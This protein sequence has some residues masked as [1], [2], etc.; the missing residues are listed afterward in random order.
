MHNR[1]TNK[2]SAM[3][4]AFLMCSTAV[5]RELTGMTADYLR[6]DGITFMEFSEMV[7]AMK[8]PKLTQPKFAE[9]RY[10]PDSDTIF[11]GDKNV[12]K[13]YG[14]FVVENGSLMLRADAAAEGSVQRLAGRGKTISLQAAEKQI[15]CEVYEGSDGS[16]IVT[17]PFQSAQVIVKS[18]KPVDRRNALDVAEGFEDLHV[19]QFASPADA[20][21]AYQ[22]YQA[23]ESIEFAVPN[24]V[25]Q[26]CGT[27]TADDTPLYQQNVNWGVSAI[28]ADEY[29]A[30]MDASGRELPEIVVAVTDT[31]IN[32]EH[33]WFK[34]RIKDG[35]VKLVF[36][37]NEGIPNDRNQH[38]SHCSGII[39]SATTSNVKIL[40]VQVLDEYG[41][42]ESL[43]IYCGVRY[44]VEQNADVISMSLG[45]F[46]GDSLLE[47]AISTAVNKDIP[48]CI[49]AGNDY[50]TDC[51]FCHPASCPNV[52]TVSALDETLEL[53]EYSNIGEMI[54]FAAPGTGIN[55]ADIASPTS[56][57]MLDGTSM[58]TPF[59]AACCADLLTYNPDLTREQI[60]QLLIRNA[61]DLGDE[62]FDRFFGNG[63]VSL[64]D[65][66]LEEKKC[67]EPQFSVADGS[68]ESAVS[69]NIT[70]ETADAEIYYTL[71]GTAPDREHGIR[72]QGEPLEIEKSTIVRA[73]SAKENY[74]SRPVSGYYIIGSKDIDNALVIED[75]VLVKYQGIFQE[76]NLKNNNEIKA[77][78]ENAF[79]GNTRLLSVTLPDS[80]GHV[81]DCAFMG[82]THLE[83]VWSNAATYGKDV[84]RSCR[85]LKDVFLTSAEA[86]GEGMFRFCTSLQTVQGLD[87]LTV[88]PAYSFYLCTKL[89]YFENSFTEIGDYAFS[90]ADLSC[91]VFNHGVIFEDVVKIGRSAFEDAFGL[92]AVDLSNCK[93]LGECAFAGSD[94]EEMT[95]SEDITV[96]PSGFLAN[97]SELFQISAPSVKE[98]GDYGLALGLWA[99]DSDWNDLGHDDW[100]A[101]ASVDHD[102]DFEHMTHL[103]TC[104]MM[105]FQSETPVNFAA[106]D[107]RNLDAFSGIYARQLI[108]PNVENA[109]PF[110]VQFGDYD[111]LTGFVGTAEVTYLENLKTV[112]E[113]A[114][115]KARLTVFGKELEPINAES[116]IG[117]A[118][119]EE[120]GGYTDSAA[121]KLA[122]DLGLQFYPIPSVILEDIPLEYD[123]SMSYPVTIH[124]KRIA[125]DGEGSWNLVAADGSLSVINCE[126]PDV[127]KM[128]MS[129]GG[130]WTFRYVLTTTVDGA[131]QRVEQ[132]VTVHVNGFCDIPSE[133]HDIVF[134]ENTLV[135]FERKPDDSMHQSVSYVFSVD[136]AWDAV[137]Y[138]SCM[139]VSIYDSES[140][141]FIDAF[142]SFGNESYYYTF[143]P[144]IEYELFC[145]YNCSEY[146]A[147]LLTDESADVIS[148]ATNGYYSEPAKQLGLLTEADLPLDLEFFDV[149]CYDN[150]NVAHVMQQDVDYRLINAQITQ[151][152]EQ[153]SYLIG[154]G[155]YFGVNYVIHTVYRELEADK[156]VTIHGA[157]ADRHFLYTAPE[158]FDGI[159]TILDDPSSVPYYDAI[160]AYSSNE[161][162][163]A[164]DTFQISVLEPISGTLT[165]GY[166]KGYLSFHFEKG[167]TYELY[168]GQCYPSMNFSS[169]LSYDFL[170]TSGKK[171]IRSADVILTGYLD[172]KGEY[173][174]D[175]QVV[176]AFTIELL[177]RG[178]DYTIEFLD[179]TTLSDF[180]VCLITGIGDYIGSGLYG[181]RKDTGE[182]VPWTVDWVEADMPFNPS[183]LALPFY[184]E[185]QEAGEYELLWQDETDAPLPAITIEGEFGSVTFDA[186]HPT[187]ALNA[188]MYWCSIDVKSIPENCPEL[189]FVNTGRLRDIGLCTLQYDIRIDGKN[190]K[191]LPDVTLYEGETILTEGVDFTVSVMNDKVY[192]GQNTMFIQGIG[193]Y[194]GYWMAMYDYLPVQKTNE[195]L[196]EGDAVFHYD[197]IADGEVAAFRWKPTESEYLLRSAGVLQN[198]I[199]LCSEAD[200]E[201]DGHY[202]V[203]TFNPTESEQ[204][205]SVVP[206]Q[207]YT[208][209]VYFKQADIQG[210][211]EFS[212]SAGCK[213]ISKCTITGSKTA[214]F[215][216][217]DYQPDFVIK[218]GDTVLKEG[219]DYEWYSTGNRI[220]A[221]VSE[222]NYRGI[223]KYY[224][225]IFGETHMYYPTLQEYRD[226]QRDTRQEELEAA[227]LVENEAST[228]YVEDMDETMLYSFTNPSS[229]DTMKFE[230]SLLP[231]L[232]AAESYA[233][234]ESD[235]LAEQ[236]Y[237]FETFGTSLFMYDE[238]GNYAGFGEKRFIITLKPDE[239]RYFVI[240]TR[241]F[242]SM[243]AIEDKVLCVRTYNEQPVIH[244]ENGF[245]YTISDYG[246]T[247]VSV[248]HSYTGLV[249]PNESDAPI[250][251][252]NLSDEDWAYLR[253]NC[254]V[255]AE[256]YGELADNIPMLALANVVRTDE[257][258]YCEGDLNGDGYV[259]RKDVFILNAVVQERIGVQYVESMEYMMERNDDGILNVLDVLLLNQ[260]LEMAAFG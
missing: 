253:D 260:M 221:G 110:H 106:A 210:K 256:N 142:S 124:A 38:G 145:S 151:A 137:L 148:F 90:R 93:D 244:E 171:S 56:T 214:V 81:G 121:E 77:I 191:M 122:Q 25:Y 5:P 129:M 32:Y 15:G 188:D 89:E 190:G 156:P 118:F 233:V 169:L 183:Y 247:L 180:V 91:V 168:A 111:L 112:K 83:T 2:I 8:T 175:E 99:V 120:I 126:V 117:D 72:Y 192:I 184:L 198:C 115:V 6:N 165:S 102:L 157:L 125:F 173:V 67:E 73:V 218:D 105:G 223:G 59:V 76:L 234:Y 21:A 74:V 259:N 109:E 255:Y 194:C 123:S 143:L 163:D 166:N 63:M 207:E 128:V 113:D 49:A 10:Q 230:V 31:G 54:S 100:I 161:Y 80:V 182:D 162:G 127:M 195:T 116:G 160:E 211:M 71:D 84:F 240:K 51:R 201:A 153:I 3:L 231:S 155:D 101:W 252:M 130:D 139:D 62:G 228:V 208:L 7:Q 82:C 149:G 29:C 134:G 20:Y 53:A 150:E 181:M 187:A 229:K 241:Q 205:I 216:G 69:L 87:D 141:E 1:H 132:D 176:D 250:V 254:I 193:D 34:G 239:T 146:G 248:D 50:G 64:K 70:C 9:L 55:S 197:S 22:A 222:Y 26:M 154:L 224:G 164:P 65:I 258:Y 4:T 88:A 58:A 52:F 14:D 33:E 119:C 57:V 46:G 204:I 61:V 133:K 92:N 220:S 144:D 257:G 196:F 170:L 13:A 98:I 43:N 94:V 19:L 40:P 189:C 227:A 212:L 200:D 159:M 66:Q 199:M 104:A 179:N 251:D 79:A 174:C 30:N 107:N 44:A 245:G 140:R 39:C 219:V 16:V 78:G 246:I 41:F 136:E 17:S 206:E 242:D 95:L 138:A 103:G 35:G 45:G 186:K 158:T 114:F 11:C 172:E 177:E 108:L 60:K 85:E 28:G 23:D 225:I 42:G 235:I 213:D 167:V 178:K 135:Q 249:L 47:A 37:D 203:F 147:F 86:I 238:D 217:E 68:Y 237:D 97:A 18:Q 209:Y 96:I 12:G 232:D 24:R 236:G 226:E 152:G 215:R 202:E 243:V 131:E 27:N 75:G 36:D 185:V 48:V